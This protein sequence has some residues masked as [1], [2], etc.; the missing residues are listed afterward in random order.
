MADK[1]HETSIFH[2]FLANL[3]LQCLHIEFLFSLFPLLT[4]FILF[5]SSY[6]FSNF[7]K[8][9]EV[10]STPEN[11]SF[12]T[13][14]LKL[15]GWALD[16]LGESCGILK[17]VPAIGPNCYTRN[18]DFRRNSSLRKG[19]FTT[20]QCY[21]IPQAPTRVV[22]VLSLPYLKVSILLSRYFEFGWQRTLILLITFQQPMLL[23]NCEKVMKTSHLCLQSAP[24]GWSY[25]IS[26]RK[27]WNERNSSYE[28]YMHLSQHISVPSSKK[29]IKQHKSSVPL[30][31]LLLPNTYTSLE[32]RKIKHLNSSI[33]FP[34][35]NITRWRGMKK[36]EQHMQRVH[37]TTHN[38]ILARSGVFCIPLMTKKGNLS[39]CHLLW[40]GVDL[41]NF[42]PN[43]F[44]VRNWGLH[45]FP[46]FT[47]Q[48]HVRRLG[49]RNSL[50]QIWPFSAKGLNLSYLNWANKLIR[51][52]GFFFIFALESPE[53]IFVH[54]LQFVIGN[55]STSHPLID[56]A[57]PGHKKK[58]RDFPM[59][60]FLIQSKLP[61]IVKKF[62]SRM[63][64]NP[65]NLSRSVIESIPRSFAMFPETS[66]VEWRFGVL[67]P[68]SKTFWPIEL[69][70]IL[71]LT[72][73]SRRD[74]IKSEA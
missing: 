29:N 43:L 40:R 61:K 52:A 74:K 60:K 26:V 5:S 68:T 31:L 20:A 70:F 14:Q 12:L 34:G 39:L 73:C 2:L 71:F 41:V 35:L 57:C 38:K 19:G 25:L 21:T 15:R 27:K 30:G 66:P 54:L 16:H 55:P 48:P 9:K 10:T 50:L 69:A 51:L 3:A 58:K 17:K 13:R 11:L 32:E 59:K 36:T 1:T 8:S 64:Q 28:Y 42:S 53:L 4:G 49:S 72:F 65:Q 23:W 33:L 24:I 22:L 67:M 7:R 62:P 45:L 47:P 6:T 18:L 46:I 56:E 44:T 63:E 37:S